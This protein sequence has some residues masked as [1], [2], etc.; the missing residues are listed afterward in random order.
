VK[1][2]KYVL[3]LWVF[4]SFVPPRGRF[5]EPMRYF[6]TVGL[7]LIGLAEVRDAI[8]NTKRA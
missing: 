5:D 1:F 7:V 4:L 3:C 8:K 6:S 2:V